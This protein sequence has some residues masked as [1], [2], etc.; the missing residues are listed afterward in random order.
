VVPTDKPNVVRITD[1]VEKPD[2]QDAPSD[3]AVIGRYVLRPEIFDLLERTEPGRGAEIQLTDA[4]KTAATQPERAGA[5]YGVIF[6]GRRY[7][8]GDKLD[9]IKATLKIAI[10]REDI[11]PD[12]RAWLQEFGKTL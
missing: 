10:D 7:D 1:L 2:A 9:Y 3:L 6:D 12:L 5:V 11:G 4:L 8:T